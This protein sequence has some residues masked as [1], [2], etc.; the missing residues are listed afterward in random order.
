MLESW[1]YDFVDL[2]EFVRSADRMFW[3][4]YDGEQ[5]CFG[6][7]N[8]PINTDSTL[9]CVNSEKCKLCSRNPNHTNNYESRRFPKWKYTFACK[10]DCSKSRHICCEECDDRNTCEDKCES[11]SD[12]FKLAMNRRKS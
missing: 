8:Q 10:C 4:I 1:K 3:I 12:E 2:D 7:T 9:A 6:C 11:K 5:D